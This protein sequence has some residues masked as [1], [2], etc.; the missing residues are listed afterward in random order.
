M[1]PRP[2]ISALHA[3][4]MSYLVPSQAGAGVD[5]AGDGARGR[6]GSPD[7][8]GA[9]DRVMGHGCGGRSTGGFA[10]A[11]AHCS[12]GILL[13]LHVLSMVLDVLP[14]RRLHWCVLVLLSVAAVPC[15]LAVS[16]A[17]VLWSWFDAFDERCWMASCVSSSEGF[18]VKGCEARRRRVHGKPSGFAVLRLHV[19]FLPRGLLK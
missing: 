11:G 5:R 10:V 7:A 12:I 18:F 17:D 1:P 2:P 6:L 3:L 14:V 16:L 19:L 9:H 4:T 15:V 8:R 13:P